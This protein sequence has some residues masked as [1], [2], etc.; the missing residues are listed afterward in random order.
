M[1]TYEPIK[2]AIGKHFKDWGFVNFDS[3]KPSE[4]YS[5]LNPIFDLGV[6]KEHQN[7]C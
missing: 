4:D 1:M 6:C 3:G 5:V 7:I 2:R